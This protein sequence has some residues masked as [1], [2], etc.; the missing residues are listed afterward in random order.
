MKLLT[1]R[2]AAKFLRKSPATL[3]CYASRNKIPSVKVLGSLR[4]RRE[5]LEELITVRPKKDGPA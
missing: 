2:Q 5:D 1:P 3:Y 4:F